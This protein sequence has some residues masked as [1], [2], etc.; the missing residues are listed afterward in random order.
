M[1]I[2][3][4]VYELV[5]MVAAEWSYLEER[6]RVAVVLHASYGL[7]KIHEPSRILVA[8]MAFDAQADVLKAFLTIGPMADPVE[9]QWFKEWCKSVEEPRRQRNTV[10]HSTW[11][12]DAEAQEPSALAVDPGSRKTRLGQNFDSFPAGIA[13]I[14]SLIERIRGRQQ[15]LAAWTHLQHLRHWPT[16]DSLF[17]SEWPKPG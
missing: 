11:V 13:G 3:D 12:Y 15:E 4:A 17:P 16:F 9:L 6:L 8:G 2:D 1:P 7:V 5:G 14:S 10:I